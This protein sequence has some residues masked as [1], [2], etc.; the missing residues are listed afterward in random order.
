MDSIIGSFDVVIECAI[1]QK[2]L[3]HGVAM[4]RCTCGVVWCGICIFDLSMF[5]AD[6]TNATLF[7]I[8]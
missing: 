3:G 2:R 6:A 1:P 5:T 4:S 7:Y 8:D